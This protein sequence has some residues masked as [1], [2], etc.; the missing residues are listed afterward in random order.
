MVVDED[1]FVV[2]SN[3]ANGEPGEVIGLSWLPAGV[4]RDVTVELDADLATS[5]LYAE[6]Y[7]D[8]ASDKEFDFPD[9]LDIPMQRNRA[10]I[11]APF[12][13]SMPDQP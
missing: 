4:N 13:L 1:A 6:L 8:A 11:R 9:G 3:D 2:I 10:I 12:N 5:T 7:L